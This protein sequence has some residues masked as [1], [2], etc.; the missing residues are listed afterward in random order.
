MLEHDQ[1][2]SALSQKRLTRIPE[3]NLLEYPIIKNERSIPLSD[4]KL[5]F[6]NAAVSNKHT[7]ILQDVIKQN[8]NVLDQS[9]T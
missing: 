2:N 5:Y 6:H 4:Q 9:L 7:E 1:T 8:K 3:K